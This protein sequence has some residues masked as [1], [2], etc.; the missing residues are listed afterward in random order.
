MD[1]DAVCDREWGRSRDGCIRWG[2]NRR[3]VW[4]VLGVNF[5]HP[6]VTNR[7]FATRLSPNYFG[8]DLLFYCACYMYGWKKSEKNVVHFIPYAVNCASSRCSLFRCCVITAGV[9]IFAFG[10]CE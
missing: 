8:R 5:G 3:R 4:A 2:G 7:D 6:I 9:R 1:P 10:Q